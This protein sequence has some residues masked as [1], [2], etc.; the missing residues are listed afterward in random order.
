MLNVLFDASQSRITLLISQHYATLFNFATYISL[1]I[2]CIHLTGTGPEWI[3]PKPPEI[4]P[5]DES[6]NLWSVLLG[7][8]SHELPAFYLNGRNIPCNLSNIPGRCVHNHRFSPFDIFRY[9]DRGILHNPVSSRFPEPW[10]STVKRI[11]IGIL[12]ISHLVALLLG[13]VISDEIFHRDDPGLLVIASDS[14][15][16]SAAD[17]QRLLREQPLRHKCKVVLTLGEP[18][19]ILRAGALRIE[20]FIA[21]WISISYSIASR[22]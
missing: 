3:E 8:I 18:A 11:K 6:V 5:I 20:D 1:K 16:V 17:L 19:A 13:G 15:V 7:N 4:L 9:T 14:S 12:V 22:Q 10:R 2:Q 21:P